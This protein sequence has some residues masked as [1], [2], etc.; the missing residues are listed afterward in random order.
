[1]ERGSS[2]GR[3]HPI[4]ILLC[5]AVFAGSL[6]LMYRLARST[7][8]RKLLIGETLKSWTPVEG[9]RHGIGT[10]LTLHVSSRDGAPREVVLEVANRRNRWHRIVPVRLSPENAARLLR[11]LEEA[12]ALA[13]VAGR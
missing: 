11:Q 8:R 12:L 5:A 4:D 9:V 7:T 13:R 6:W 10:D 3:R 2:S 1:M